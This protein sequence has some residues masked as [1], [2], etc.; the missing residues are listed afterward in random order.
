MIRIA[1][2][3]MPDTQPATYF[4]KP[5]NEQGFQTASEVYIIDVTKSNYSVDHAK[6]RNDG[7]HVFADNNSDIQFHLA[8]LVELA[9]KLDQ[10][11][12]TRDRKA[13]YPL[14]TALKEWFDS[15]PDGGLAKQH[16]DDLIELVES[17]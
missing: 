5:P 11:F 2:W 17:R 13:P 12:S 15:L 14:R 4:P 9:G 16:L 1:L 6:S 7:S 3:Y 10:T 8:E